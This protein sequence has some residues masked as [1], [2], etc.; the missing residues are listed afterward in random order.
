MISLVDGSIVF[1]LVSL[2][3][4]HFLPTHADSLL[5]SPVPPVAVRKFPTPTQPEDDL[6][7]KDTFGISRL[8]SLFY[9][10]SLY[11]PML[12]RERECVCLR[13]LKRT[14]NASGEQQQQLGPSA[15]SPV[16]EATTNDGCDRDRRQCEGFALSRSMRANFTKCLWP[17]PPP[18]DSLVRICVHKCM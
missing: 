13:R 15:P 11:G 8:L 3:L 1:L 14:T 10:S 16:E 2:S 4:F 9:A 6:P 7:P 12:E 17:P 18:C 5:L